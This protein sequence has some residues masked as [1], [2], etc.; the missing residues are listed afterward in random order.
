M[1][2]YTALM[3]QGK[4]LTLLR[5]QLI[6]NIQLNNVLELLRL[7]NNTTYRNEQIFA[8][9]KQLKMLLPSALLSNIQCHEHYCEVCLSWLNSKRKAICLGAFVPGLPYWN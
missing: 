9:Q 2:M 3:Q 4:N 1:G 8:W 5:E 7:S 6:A